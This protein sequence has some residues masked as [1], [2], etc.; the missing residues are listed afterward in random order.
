[1]SFNRYDLKAEHTGFVP[2]GLTLLYIS[3]SRYGEDWHSTPHAHGFTELFFVTGGRGSFR[4]RQQSFVVEEGDMVIVDP[5]VEHTETSVSEMPL[6]YIVLGVDGFV[7]P[8]GGEQEQ[9]CRVIRFRES[10]QGILQPLRGILWEME[11]RESG[12]ENVCQSLLQVLLV[13]VARQVGFTDLP[14]PTQASRESTAARRYIDNHYRENLTLESLAQAVH[15]SKYHLA[16]IFSREY[17]ISPINYMLSLRLQECRD[18]LRT[19][20]YSVAQVARITGF[21]SPS[22]FSQRF[23]QAEGMTPAQYR[24]RNKK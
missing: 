22:Y 8:Q 17:G 10:A 18:L 2:A 4:I 11:R 14:A 5:N 6:E 16:H 13:R 24:Q 9:P 12:F 20:D 15:I 21:S 1:M 7:Q 3:A 19:T 23:R